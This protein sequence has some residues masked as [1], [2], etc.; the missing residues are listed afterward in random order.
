[1]FLRITFVFSSDVWLVIVGRGLV[2]AILELMYVLL[3]I[4]VFRAISIF[5]YPG[6]HEELGISVQ[7]VFWSLEIIHFVFIVIS[8]ETRHHALVSEIGINHKFLILDH[9]RYFVWDFY[10]PF[11]MLVDDLSK[12]VSG[13]ILDNLLAFWFDNFIINLK[14]VLKK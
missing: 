6:L 9:T 5:R 8:T 10:S 4:G 12:N 13:N 7:A 14:N 2:A 1:M 3:V 11:T